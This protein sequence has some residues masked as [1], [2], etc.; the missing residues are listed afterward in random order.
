MTILLRQRTLGSPITLEGFGYWSGEDV[1]IQ[2]R[3]AAAHTG[4]VFV[5]RD[6]P[7]QPRVAALAAHRLDTP[8][9]TSLERGPARVEMVE[10][11]LAAL[12]ALGVD[13][14]EIWVDRPEMPGF[15]G[16]SDPFVRAILAAGIVDLTASRRRLVVHRGLRLGDDDC[17]VE[18]RPNPQGGLHVAYE[19]DYGPGPIGRQ[20]LALDINA[21][22]FVR[23]LS[24]ARTFLLAS[25]AEWMRR[26]GLGLRVT[27]RDLL[28]FGPQGPLENTLRFD[29]ECVRHKALDLIG[30]LALASCDIVGTIVAH[31]SGHRL[32]AELV[33]ALLQAHY[34]DC[35]QIA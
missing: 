3:P 8:R 27:T 28:V 25:E 20:S 16:S 15:D 22:S 21:D 9:R 7:G 13:N 6:L 31:R 4:L 17:W 18:A 30:D 24:T 14:C 33:S 32:N 23:E 26:Q 10:H 2:F 19:L 5:R 29:N 12:T 35:R 1:R 34:N 11:I